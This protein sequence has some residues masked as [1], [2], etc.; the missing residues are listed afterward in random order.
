MKKRSVLIFIFLVIISL[1][2]VTAVGS[3]SNL[4]QKVE[5]I[6][7]EITDYF[8]FSCPSGDE[9]KIRYDNQ[10]NEAIIL[11]HDQKYILQRAISGSGARYVNDDESIV[12]WEHHGEA[13][14]EVDGEIVAKSC[15]LD[16]R[17]EQWKEFIAGDM[18]FK[19]P[20][21]LEEKCISLQKWPPEIKILANEND[22]PLVIEIK[23]GKLTCQTTPEE[24]SFSKRFFQQDVDERTYCI[25][26][27]SE[28]AAGSVYTDYTYYTIY[29]GNLIA[30]NFVLRFTNCSHYSEPQSL[31]CRAEREAF[32]IGNTINKIVDSIA[33]F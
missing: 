32:D 11:F 20:E 26:A 14:L 17:S 25:R 6:A 9:L 1:F 19:A 12:F 3:Q 24:S 7:P 29:K 18:L 23:N 33:C 15:S 31:E 27:E 10:N 16:E 8:I 5:E 4:G 22:W 30:I 28:G 21:S 13:T 2:S